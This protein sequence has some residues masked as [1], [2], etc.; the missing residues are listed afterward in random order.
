MLAYWLRDD[1][2]P[3]LIPDAVV[4]PI[5]H[6][7]EWANAP[8]LSSSA[9]HLQEFVEAM[10]SFNKTLGINDN[11]IAANETAHIAL[12]FKGG[13]FTSVIPSALVGGGVLHSRGVGNVWTSYQCSCFASDDGGEMGCSLEN[14]DNVHICR[15]E[16]CT[17]TCE[18]RIEVGGR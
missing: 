4:R 14:S 18:M 10:Q 5:K 3:K 12:M 16:S 2:A 7:E 9:V 8:Y 13:K 17:G 1:E 15:D 6:V 11:V